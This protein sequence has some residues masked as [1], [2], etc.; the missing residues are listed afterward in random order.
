MFIT[1][2]S[3]NTNLLCR[4]RYRVCTRSS[5][6]HSRLCTNVEDCGSNPVWE[7]K[8]RFQSL[9]ISKKMVPAV[10]TNEVYTGT[11]IQIAKPNGGDDNRSCNQQSKVVETKTGLVFREMSRGWCIPCDWESQVDLVTQTSPVSS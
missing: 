10:G 4:C 9:H 8:R 2:L 6:N 11:A 7:C 3:G 5:W 1:L